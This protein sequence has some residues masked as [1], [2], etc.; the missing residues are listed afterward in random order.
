MN[1]QE[2]LIRKFYSAFQQKDFL[3]MQSCYHKDATFSDPV[4]PNLDSKEVKAMWEML[5]K[6]SKDLRIEFNEIHSKDQNRVSS[7]GCVVFVLTN[8]PAGSQ[9]HFRNIRI[10]G[11][12]H[13]SAPG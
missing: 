3:V 10:P 2:D 9:H 7:L 1:Y 6:S 4:F 12:T 13:L 5:L 8:G 11:W